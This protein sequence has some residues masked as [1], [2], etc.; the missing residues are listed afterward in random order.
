[1]ETERL[2]IFDEQ[3]NLIG[4][5]TR[6]EVHKKGHWH[7]TFHCWL[8]SREAEGN[9][10][11]FQ[12][13]SAGKKDYPNLLDITAAGHLLANETVEDGVREVKEEIGID[14]SIEE[15]LS[16]GIISYSNK[17]EDLIDNELAHVF[18]LEKNFSFDDFHLQ[19]E[20]VSGI[21]KIDI[22]D[23]YE[24]WFGDR[25][26]IKVIGFEMKEDRSRKTVE[27]FVGKREFVSHEDRFYEDTLDAI[28]STLERRATSEY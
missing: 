1:M 6:E 15:L 23:F 17:H 21:V 16:L 18:L 25:E 4:V 28:Q 2:K 11:Y 20:E 9:Y 13:R 12:L 27:K 19:L 3:R 7:E 10:L 24:L 5:A 26:E 8:V 22:Q 14:V